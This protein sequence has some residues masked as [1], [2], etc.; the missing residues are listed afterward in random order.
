ME[1]GDVE[2][3]LVI[4][5]RK[6]HGETNF[7]RS[8]VTPTRVADPGHYFTDAMIEIAYDNRTHADFTGAPTL[9]SHVP[10]ACRVKGLAA[11]FPRKLR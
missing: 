9:Q 7:I 5:A 1:L 3:I 11:R 6:A 8:S 10:E 4:Y 2:R